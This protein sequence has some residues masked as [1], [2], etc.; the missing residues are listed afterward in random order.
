MPGIARLARSEEESTT[1][2]G[3]QRFLVFFPL[4]ACVP[5]AW[6]SAEIKQKPTE[7]H[8]HLPK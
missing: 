5:F 7:N 8:L 4:S 1:Q 2:Q 6:K 3:V